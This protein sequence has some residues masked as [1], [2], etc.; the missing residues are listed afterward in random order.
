[1]RWSRQHDQLL[2]YYVD[3]KR[4]LIDIANILDIALPEIK[5]RCRKLELL[6]DVKLV[7]RWTEEDDERLQELL[8]QGKSAAEIGKL[9]DRSRNSVI[10]RS[11][12]LK[13][14]FSVSIEKKDIEPP[15]KRVFKKRPKY[16]NAA[17]DAIWS[18]EQGECKYP[19]GGH[20]YEDTFRFCCA[21]QRSGSPYCEQHHKLCYYPSRHQIAAQA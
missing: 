1:M 19:I 2:K 21:P 5:S 8:K 13:N 7:H 20:P 15:A 17:R 10:G 14:T 18:L 11:N 3:K 9:L 6:D 16:N 4:S 12:R